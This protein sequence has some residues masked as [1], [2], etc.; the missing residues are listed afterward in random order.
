MKFKVSPSSDAPNL[1]VEN[2]ETTEA[3]SARTRKRCWMRVQQRFLYFCAAF[4]TR[5]PIIFFPIAV[6]LILKRARMPIYPPSITQITLCGV[7][8]PL[9][10]PLRVT[11]DD[12]VFMLI[13]S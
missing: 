12:G 4:S 5:Q 2:E 1:Q 8:R 11:Q 9:V 10:K 13:V 6:R 7:T 3:P